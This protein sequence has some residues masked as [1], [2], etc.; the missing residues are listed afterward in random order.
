MIES[1]LVANVFD[2]DNY[3]MSTRRIGITGEFS[4]RNKN[5]LNRNIAFSKLGMDFSGIPQ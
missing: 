4:L 3:L 1:T 5:E 2:E